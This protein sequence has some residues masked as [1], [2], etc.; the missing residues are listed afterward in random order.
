MPCP[1]RKAPPE[2]KR[3]VAA[4][5]LLENSP[6]PPFNRLKRASKVDTSLPGQ[7]PRIIF[8]AL[9]IM[10]VGALVLLPTGVGLIDA[11]IKHGL[12]RSRTRNCASTTAIGVTMLVGIWRAPCRVGDR[13]R[14]RQRS[15]GRCAEFWQREMPHFHLP[16]A[17]IDSS[18]K[19]PDNIVRVSRIGAL[20]RFG[21][22]S[23]KPTSRCHS[24]GW[25]SV[26]EGNSPN[27]DRYSPAKRPNCQKP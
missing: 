23:E 24:R 6:A 22:I 7:L 10:I 3:R 4:Q 8:A 1:G 19:M 21:K 25:L 14:S 2:T 11:S 15:S 9:A 16:P 20:F 12:L 26:A 17:I 5:S 13:N 18:T 27:S